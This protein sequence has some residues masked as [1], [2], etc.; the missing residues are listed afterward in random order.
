VLMSVSLSP[1]VAAHAAWDIDPRRTAAVAAVESEI[2]L[3]RSYLA[4]VVPAKA[5]KLAFTVFALA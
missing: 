1:L 4:R 5:M 3:M 2:R